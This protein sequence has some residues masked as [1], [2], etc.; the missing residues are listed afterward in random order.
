[1]RVSFE[2]AEAASPAN[3]GDDTA[4]QISTGP[5]TSSDELALYVC[6]LEELEN[7]AS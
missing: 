7:E 3:I 1:M 4:G 6:V 2:K 5:G